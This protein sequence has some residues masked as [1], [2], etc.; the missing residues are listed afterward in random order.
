MDHKERRH[1]GQGQ[2]SLKKNNACADKILIG[3]AY[4]IAIQPASSTQVFI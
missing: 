3:F 2:A 4:P 1:A